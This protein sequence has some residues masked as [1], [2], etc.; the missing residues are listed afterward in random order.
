MP[1]TFTYTLADLEEA[2]AAT[3]K[4]AKPPRSRKLMA[5][6]MVFVFFA[7]LTF[8]LLTGNRTPVASAT[9]PIPTPVST[10]DLGSLLTPHISLALFF[11]LILVLGKAAGARNRRP[12]LS[13]KDRQK[14]VTR[15]GKAF[16]VLI[17]TLVFLNF[18]VAGRDQPILIESLTPSGQLWLCY[19]PW[20]IAIILLAFILSRNKGQAVQDQWAMKKSYRRPKE[21]EFDTEAFTIRDEA[22]E[23]RVRWALLERYG[24]T[25]NLLIVYDENSLMYFFPKRAFASEEELMRFR[26]VIH[27]NIAEGEFLPQTSAFPVSVPQ[28]VLPVE[29]DA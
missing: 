27:T 24:E 4:S 29:G 6:W 17:V 19:L 11:V 20:G 1:A 15:L 12:D 10:V 25:R 26:G 28:P 21:L 22:S 5:G 13:Q 3:N 9:Q 16:L 18:Y 23:H 14:T 2:T 8:L 7:M